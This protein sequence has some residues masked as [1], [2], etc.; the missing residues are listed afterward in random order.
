MTQQRGSTSQILIDDETTYAVSPTTPNASVLPF[1]TE[2]LR[3]SRDMV[4]SAT[5]M[6]SRSARKPVR[7]KLNVAGDI[8][9]E[10]APQYGRLLRHLFGNYASS[11]SA[12]PYTHTFKIGN[13]PA[14]MVVEKQFADVGKFF[15]YNGC[16]IATF[17]TSVSPSGMISSS[18]GLIG[19]EEIVSTSSIDTTPI[20]LGHTPFDGFS[21]SILQGGASLAT[22]TKI[23]FQIDNGLDQDQYVIDGTGRRRS[24]PEGT[25]K[26]SGTLE[27]LFDSTTL[28]DLAVNNTET[29]LQLDFVLGT[30]TGA[31]VGNEKLSFIFEEMLFSPQASVVDGPKGLKYNL[32]FVAYY[33][34][35]ADASSCREVLLSPVAAF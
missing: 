24:L 35:A 9:F 4:Q 22:G 1:V 21:A 7:G 5:I 6:A 14:G 20:N 34:D 29:T 33:N 3:M 18:V 19:A 13:L 25:A 31:S 28:Y 8:N 10:L 12:A 30:G 2:T 11:G 26:V 27:V 17:K 15:L 16:K 23:D 32:P